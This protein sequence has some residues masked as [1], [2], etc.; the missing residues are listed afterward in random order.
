MSQEQISPLHLNPEQYCTYLLFYSHI[1][2]FYM[3]WNVL[4]L[5]GDFEGALK[6][7]VYLFG[8]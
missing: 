4:E 1:A 7:E 3:L 2:I 6:G 8:C 5:K